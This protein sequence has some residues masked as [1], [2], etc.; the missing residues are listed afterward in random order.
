[1]LTT[2]YDGNT[3]APLCFDDAMVIAAIQ[4][5]SATTCLLFSNGP[6]FVVAGGCEVIMGGFSPGVREALTDLS[7]VNKGVPFYLAP[8][9]I[10]QIMPVM[11][12]QNVLFGKTEI[13]LKTGAKI[14]IPSG[15]SDVIHAITGERVQEP[16]RLKLAGLDEVESPTPD[17]NGKV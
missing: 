2:L 11:D 12:G 13:I 10:G 16:S 9:A 7:G 4:M 1:M 6:R 5:P 15:P 3:G 14:G 17:S 8:N